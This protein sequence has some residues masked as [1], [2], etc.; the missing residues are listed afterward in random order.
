M[1]TLTFI[2]AVAALAI[3]LSKQRQ[4][5]QLSERLAH[6]ERASGI[7]RPNTPPS[8]VKPVADAPAAPTAATPPQAAPPAAVPLEDEP[9]VAF[10]PPPPPLREEEPAFVPPPEP[11]RAKRPPISIE[12]LIGVHLPVW[13]GAAMLLIGSFFLVRMAASSGFFTPTIG[14][15]AAAA[16]GFAMLAAAFAVR[17]FR[18]ANHAQIGAALASAAIGTFYATAFA[19][20]AIFELT[21]LETGF[22]LSAATAL[23]SFG[24]ALL[25][26]RPVLIVGL[27]GAYL[28]PMLLLPAAPEGPLLQLYLAALLTGA[29]L[30]CLKRNWSG[31]LTLVLV[32]HGLWLLVSTGSVVLEG[33]DAVPTAFL[34]VFSPA[35]IWAVSEVFGRSSASVPVIFGLAISLVITALGT[36]ALEFGP[37]MLGAFS[38]LLLLGGG[39][40]LLDKNRSILP[41]ALAAVSWLLLLALWREPDAGTR[42]LETVIALVAVGVPLIAALL[43]GRHSTRAALLFSVTLMLTTISTMVDLDGVGG[44]R[45]LPALWAAI[46][47]FV[48]L[49]MAGLARL[50]WSRT[51]KGERQRV[52]AI[53]AASSSGFVSLAVVAV[54]NPDFFALAAALQV[55]GVALV[56]RRFPVIDLRSLIGVYALAYAAL[57]AI[58]IFAGTDLYP[59]H[60][61]AAYLPQ[62]PLWEA[63]IAALLLPAVA[64]LAAATVLVGAVRKPIADLLDGAAVFLVAAAATFII[65]P[66]PSFIEDVDT[67]YWSSIWFVPVLL[68]GLSALAA[69]QR[70]KRHGLQLAGTALSGVVLLA[71]LVFVGLP[72]YQL[73]PSWAVPGLPVFNVSITGLALPGLL[74]LALAWLWQAEDGD[75]VR[76]ARIGTVILGGFLIVTGLLVAIRHLFHPELLQGPS[77]PIERYS[78][79]G[80]LLILAFAALAAG[81]RFNTQALR[82]GSLAIM[83]VTV[84]K[85]FIFDMGGL[86]GLWR[87]ASFVAMGCALLATSW[88]YARFVFPRFSEKAES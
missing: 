54:V 8:W 62:T 15:G 81:A 68:I 64:F 73:W 33:A 31:L 69:G 22:I 40:S 50:I 30:S 28:A 52:G 59:N 63:E 23:V 2:I 17:Q 16:T 35:L 43:A 82:L 34:L 11:P 41:V 4:I 18:I 42:I 20:S 26:G 13:G 60:A 36:A 39:M 77:G 88:V 74:A 55:L 75:A 57:L 58:S 7:G 76:Y 47:L 87:V 72:P 85:V 38:V 37:V 66:D 21:S 9:A 1:E 65:V 10:G 71:V 83:L 19:A 70:L 67:L 29:T 80:G 12:R 45:D 48:A 44:M 3:A 56:Q 49:A 6:L 84:A 27:I 5:K 51:P 24:I 79:S 61:I 53:L 46:S 25:F 78:Y 14:I 86:E 32:L